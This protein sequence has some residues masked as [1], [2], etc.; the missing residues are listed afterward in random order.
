MREETTADDFCMR[1]GFRRSSHNVIPPGRI[2][3]DFVE[4]TPDRD[5]PM[6]TPLTPICNRYV[7]QAMV[8]AC[9]AC[10]G[11]FADDDVIAVRFAPLAHVAGIAYDPVAYHERCAVPTLRRAALPRYA[12]HDGCAPDCKAPDAE[13]HK[14]ALGRRMRV[15][16]PAAEARDGTH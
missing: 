1:C 3:A 8:F 5:D 13:A 11:T 10:G 15:T 6:T 14:P 7:P 16:P 4:P 2:C 12:P 9:A